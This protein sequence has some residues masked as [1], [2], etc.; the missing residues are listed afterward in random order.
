M[1]FYKLFGALLFSDKSQLHF[2]SYCMYLPHHIT[3]HRKRD[4]ISQDTYKWCEWSFLKWWHWL[5]PEGIYLPFYNENEDTICIKL[6]TRIQLWHRQRHHFVREKV[7]C[8]HLQA[9]SPVEGDNST[10]RGSRQ[11]HPGAVHHHQVVLQA[12]LVPRAH[13]EHPLPIDL[14][15]A[16]RQS[17]HMTGLPLCVSGVTNPNASVRCYSI[18]VSTTTMELWRDCF[19]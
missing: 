18:N 13:M 1:I 7:I 17:I 6:W 5:Y 16:Q 14:P 15:T 19:T 9:V 10:V 4:I 3:Q 2:G 12:R 11:L 8:S